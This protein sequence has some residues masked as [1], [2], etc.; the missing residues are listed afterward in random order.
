MGR[1]PSAQARE[2]EGLLLLERIWGLLQHADGPEPV[3]GAVLEAVTETLKG[4][5]GALWLHG[6]ARLVHVA[7]RGFSEGFLR[8]AETLDP[9]VC[10]WM[11]VP[12]SPRGK[13]VPSLLKQE[14]IRSYAWAPLPGQ[15]A[16]LGNILLGSRKARPFSTRSRQL[17]NAVGW[18]L[19]TAWMYARTVR[20]LRAQQAAI[21]R[22][23]H[24]AL[25]A[26]ETERQRIYKTL[27]DSLGQSLGAIGVSVTLATAHV[28]RELGA[29]RKELEET[30]RLVGQAIED[31]RSLVKDI[32]PPMLHPGGLDSALDWLVRQFRLRSGLRV[33]FRASPLKDIPSHIAIHLYRVL[34]EALNNVKRHAQADRVQVSLFQKGACL[35]MSV[36]D[37][38]VGFQQGAGSKG[39]GL[40]G[41]EE[42]VRA[43]GGQFR[44]VSWPGRGTRIQV[45]IP[46]GASP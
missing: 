41:M 44:I 14:G 10:P 19:G 28:P 20:A 9:Q 46:L 42:R 4:D 5:A 12:V 38:G 6:E 30:A 1:V 2:G 17:L 26:E 45:E 23:S 39:L 22:L 32:W 36:R 33:S 24:E 43:L 15:A 7:S 35:V 8:Q 40:V 27:H 18:Q 31:F 21:R 25:R 11:E 16:P 13:S 29:L 34:Q 3:A 37:N